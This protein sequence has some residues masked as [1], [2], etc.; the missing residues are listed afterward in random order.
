MAI[1]RLRFDPVLRW[2]QQALPAHAAFCLA[3]AHDCR[4]GMNDAFRYLAAVWRL[5]RVLESA[6]G[7]A[8]VFLGRT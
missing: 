4:C 8:V 1:F 6:I 5:L 7:I 3:Y 2:P